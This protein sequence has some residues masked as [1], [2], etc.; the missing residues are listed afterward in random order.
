MKITI[1]HGSTQIQIS[2]AK[3]MKKSKKLIQDIFNLLPKEVEVEEEEPEPNPIGFSVGATTE[4][5]EETVDY[6]W[7]D[8]E[9]CE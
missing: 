7:D 5:A 3:S 9:Y 8:D 4:R 1:V 2:G 6:I